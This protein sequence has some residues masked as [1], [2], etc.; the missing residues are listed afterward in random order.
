MNNISKS[1]SSLITN[2]HFNDLSLNEIDQT[3]KVVLDLIGVSFAGFKTM[4][5]P[6]MMINYFN[7]IG[8]KPE[9]TVIQGGNKVPAI[10]AAFANA[11]CAHAI[12]MD[13]GHRFS[14]SHPGSVVI[15]AAIAAAEMREANTKDLITAIVIGY[16][17][18]IRIGKAITPSSLARGFHITGITGSFGAAAATAKIM[19]LNFEQTVASLGMAGLQSSGLIQVNHELEGSMAKPINPARAAMSGVLSCIFA[20][21]GVHAPIEI[22]E[23]TDG[24]L[25]AF[26]DEVDADILVQNYDNGFEIS[27]VYIKMYSACRHAH[28]PIDAAYEA[29]QNGSMSIDQID[30]ITVETYPAAIRLAGIQNATTPS[31]GRFSIP[32]SVALYLV[33]KDASADKYCEESINDPDIQRLA[34][35]IEMIASEEW[36]SVYP[37]KR[38]ATVTIVNKDRSSASAKVY[39]ARGEPENPASWDEVYDKFAKNSSYVL[40]GDEITNLY[41]IITNLDKSSIDALT[42]YM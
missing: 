19:G 22:F 27:N 29:L 28:A 6:Q 4:N 32:F 36:S 39:L 41:N 2:T 20:E 9:A 25:K 1:I 23:G 11:C 17:V 37:E 15:P 5:F 26:A 8:G 3:K 35:K 33:K 21:K 13:D 12:D 10:N 16:E 24:F 34:K 14:A 40:S 42:S 18:M 38:G 7:Y 31:A 30:K